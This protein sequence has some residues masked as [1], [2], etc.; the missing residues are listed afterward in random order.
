MKRFLLM[1]LLAVVLLVV[2]SCGGNSTNKDESN[3]ASSQ[4]DATL[5]QAVPVADSLKSDNDS[6]A[7][8]DSK[9][10]GDKVVVI[11][12]FATWCGPCKAM[13]PAMEKMEKK[14]GDKI[15]FRKVDVDQDPE[16]AQQ[17]QIEGVPT[18]VIL[19]SKGDV[20]NKI[21]G[22]QT[23]EFLDKMFSSL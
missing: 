1:S 14:Y 10:K 13:A 8:T 22:G 11:D 15:E 7:Q 6:V 12:F 16:L 17:Y 2:A 19:S 23:E 18:L 9:K 21:V 20:L 3:S 5:E 4:P